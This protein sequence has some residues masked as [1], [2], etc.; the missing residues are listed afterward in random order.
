MLHRNI[1][2]WQRVDPATG[3]IPV[4]NAGTAHSDASGRSPAPLRAWGIC[5]WNPVNR[6]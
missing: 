1:R 4:I 6:R 5:A 3:Q 2:V